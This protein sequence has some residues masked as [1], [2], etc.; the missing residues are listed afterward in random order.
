MNR[1]YSY[2]TGKIIYVLTGLAVLVN[3]SGLFDT[4]IGPD[5]ALYASISKIMVLKNDF[6]NLFSGGGDWL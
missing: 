5:V 4:I 2:F 3:L 1:L 6:V